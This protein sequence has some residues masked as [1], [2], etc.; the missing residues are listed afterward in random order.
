VVVLAAHPDDETLGA[1]GLIAHAASAGAS[2]DVVVATHGEAS[3]PSSPTTTA[4]QLADRRGAEVRA[5]VA[6]LAPEAEVH[7]LGLPDGELAQHR[8]DLAGHLLRIVR[9]QTHAADV[10]VAPWRGDAHADHDVAGAV[11]AECAAALGISLLEYPVWAWHWAV[12]ADSRVPWAQAASLPLDD[13]STSRKRAALQLHRSQTEP[14]S[15]LPGDEA[16]LSPQVLQHFERDHEVFL[17]TPATARPSL[18]ARF[19]DDFYRRGGDDPWGFESRWYERRKLDLVLASLPRERFR[20]AFEP[21]CSIGVLTRALADRCD[22]LLAIDPAS[23]AVERARRRLAGHDRVQVRRGS[24]PADWPDGV[25][26]LVVLSEL[27]YYCDAGDLD[28]LARRATEALP[29]GGVLVACHWRHPVSE[30]PLGGDDVHARLRAEPGLS[31]LARHEEADFLLDVLVK[32][33]ATSVA[34]ATGLL[35]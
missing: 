7:L 31:P 15:D 14:L 32:G 26:D 24:V 17:L 35:S 12:P 4:S 3:H 6:L 11:A 8:D 20:R 29:D 30:Y 1:G 2:V 34:R 22:E 23:F 19:F 10:L 18:D 5:S 21:G 25:F 33:P 16:L 13:A 9:G 27:G 28:L